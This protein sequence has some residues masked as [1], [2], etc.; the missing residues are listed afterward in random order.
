MDG[1]TIVDTIKN[2]CLA[3]ILSLRAAG[4][5]F[6]LEDNLLAFIQALVTIHVDGRKMNE[7]IAAALFIDETIT[8]FVVK[9]FYCTVSQD[10][11]L[12]F[13]VRSVR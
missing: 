7:N 3:Y 11:T 2:S 8:F 5:L 6:N 4:A 13:Q 12:L 1:I 9:P 10:L